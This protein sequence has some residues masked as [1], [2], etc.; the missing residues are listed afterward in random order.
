MV[1]TSALFTIVVAIL[2]LILLLDGT[3]GRGDGFI[4]IL[5]F[6]GYIFWIF[7]KEERF[8]KIYNHQGEKIEIVKDLK[9]FM[10]NL[11][12][13]I[14]SLVL[15]LGASEGVVLTVR[16]FVSNFNLPLELVAILVVGLGNVLPEGYFAIA[17]ARKGQTWMILGNLMGSVIVPS[18][19]VLGIVALIHP[20]RVFNFSPFAIAR[21]FLVLAAFLFLIAVRSDQKITK[22]EAWF[23]ILIYVIFVIVEI[24]IGL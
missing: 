5:C 17:S 20:I 18:T 8:K 21:I 2:P 23:L 19:L 3:L 16:F 4:L 12:I 22:K 11:V 14:L 10:K 15:L 13:M 9:D 6:F 7:S 24:L 1:Q